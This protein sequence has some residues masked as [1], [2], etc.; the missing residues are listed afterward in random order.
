MKLLLVA[1]ALQEALAKLKLKLT[2]RNPTCRRPRW[3]CPWRR[4]RCR[5][6]W[7]RTT[8]ARCATT[9]WPRGESTLTAWMHTAA[10]P[11]QCWQHHESSSSA[12]RAGLLMNANR[13]AVL[14]GK[15]QMLI[16]PRDSREKAE[17]RRE[18]RRRKRDA[19]E[20]AVKAAKDK[21][22]KAND[23]QPSGGDCQ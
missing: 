22:R 7:P 4:R 8:A 14:M 11:R 5:R 18:E 21:E 19:E 3:S 20:A 9:C 13:A 17:T 16:Y 10:A 15:H 6:R 1:D 23:V 2:F 12:A